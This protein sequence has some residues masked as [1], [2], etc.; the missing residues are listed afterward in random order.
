MDNFWRRY[1]DQHL[2]VKVDKFSAFSY[3]DILRQLLYSTISF[4]LCFLLSYMTLY[5]KYCC[6]TSKWSVF[7]LVVFVLD[8]EQSLPFW[9]INSQSWQILTI[10]VQWYLQ[11]AFIFDH[12]LLAVLTFILYDPIFFRWLSNIKVISVYFGGI[13]LGFRPFFA[14][15]NN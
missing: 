3:I 13:W 14:I 15:L 7:I 4:W 8:F 6:L 12:I 1:A 2:T 9:K 11:T 10:L 5:F